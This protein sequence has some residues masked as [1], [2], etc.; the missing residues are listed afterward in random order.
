MK[1]FLLLFVTFVIFG[2]IC[3]F[4]YS[5]ETPKKWL[6]P[7]QIKTYIPADHKR[8]EMMKHAFMEWSRKT[9][10]NVVFKYVDTPQNAQLQV[11]FVNTIPNADREIGLTKSN[12]LQSGKIIRAQ[13]FIA[14]KTSDGRVLGND[15]VYTVMLHEIG[16]SIGIY[17]HSKNPKS[18]MY[19]TEDDIQEILSSDL[20][21][22]GNIYGW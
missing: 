18:I 10:N 15:S 8:S 13:I 16:H 4:A 1:K 9:N 22:L 5:T 3:N 11:F 17:E 7:K 2:M 19:P 12:F 14:E 6:Y 20:K 21:T